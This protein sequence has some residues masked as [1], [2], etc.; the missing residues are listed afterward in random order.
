M[1]VLLYGHR[2]WIGSQIVKHWQTQYPEDLLTLSDTRVEFSQ[3]KRLEQEINT[4][5]VV[6]CSVGRTSGATINNIDYLEDKLS[7][8]LSD[9]LAAPV[10]LALI[11]QRLGKHLSYIGTGCIFSRDTRQDSYQYDETSLPDFQGS[12]YSTV[13]G[14]TD[15]LMHQL[16]HT[17]LNFRIRMPIVDWNCP[18]NFITKLCSFSKICSFPNS[19]TYLPDL[20]PVMVELTRHQKK[21]T[22]NMV[23]PGAI[24]HETILQMTKNHNPSQQWELVEDL[25]HILKAKR[26][27]NRLSTS[28][29][30]INGYNLRDIHECVEEAVQSMFNSV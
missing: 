22:I 24:S 25:G 19:M 9:N 18:K 5:D 21:G 20:I 15:C 17:V 11:C 10:L 1:R 30:E 23:N 3:A 27:N 4:V 6:F 26:S 8:N 13:K 29:L 16:E 2:G 14:V 12:A 7:E 28:G